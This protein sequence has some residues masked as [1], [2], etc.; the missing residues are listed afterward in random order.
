[1]LC[2]PLRPLGCVLGVL[3]ACA[4]VTAADPVVPTF[5]VRTIDSHAGEIVYA[6]THADVDGDGQQDIVAVTEDRVL[7]YQ[8]PDWNKRVILS[9]QTVRDNVCIAAHDIDGDGKIDFALGAG[10][11]KSGGTIQW[12]SRSQTLDEPWTVHFIGEIPWTHRM[13][14]ADVLG[15]GSSQLVVSPLNAADGEAGV[16]LT[17][18]TVPSHPQTDRWPATVLDASLNRL[19]NHWH[20]PAEF[21]GEERPAVTFTASQEGLHE[22]FAAPHAA[23]T[24]P[25][26]EKIKLAD[27]ATGDAPAERGAGEVKTGRLADGRRLIASI[28]PM[29][30]THAVVYVD[31]VPM[32]ISAEPRWMRQVLDD[33]LRRGHALWLADLNGDGTD[34]VIVGHSEPSPG[35]IKGPGVYVYWAGNSTADKWTKQVIDNGGMACED[36]FVLDLTGDGRPDIVAGGRETHNVTLYVNTAPR[37]GK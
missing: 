37:N 36:L 31:T 33:T 12:L 14:W 23:G 10:W 2:N 9:G 28:E 30:G 6:V 26:F 11:P 19:H 25:T 13:R 18:F 35:P 22:V 21:G 16:R 32:G 34:E 24:A 15:S 17:A 7:W 29:H 27:G 4:A 8:S 1:M 20:A 5:Q 3:V